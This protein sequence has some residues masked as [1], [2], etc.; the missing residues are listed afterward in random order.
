M[1]VML[2]SPLAVMLEEGVGM[3]LWWAFFMVAGLVFYTQPAFA[4]EAGQE[5]AYPSTESVFNAAKKR[6][7]TGGKEDWLYFARSLDGNLKGSHVDPQQATQWYR[8]A[9]EAGNAEAAYAMGKRYEEGY[10]VEQDDRKAFEWY[11]RA[12]EARF[13]PAMGKVGKFH[14]YGKAIPQS[15]VEA[16]FWFERMRHPWFRQPE[17]AAQAAAKLTPREMA[18]VQERLAAVRA[19]ERNRDKIAK[20]KGKLSHPFARWWGWPIF[21]WSIL[22]GASFRQESFKHATGAPFWVWLGISFSAGCLAGMLL[23]AASVAT[24][25]FIFLGVLLFVLGMFAVSALL[26]G[27]CVLL[28][29][30]FFC[31]DKIQTRLR[32]AGI[33]VGSFA[34]GGMFGALVLIKPVVRLFS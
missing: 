20:F 22:L 34:G 25:A 8:R 1:P 7:E 30:S 33:A 21:L 28:F 9:A 27:S 29:S 26:W 4:A 2:F 18:A 32:L 13:G 23:M 15:Y 11:M 3:H 10:T 5:S 16:S 31:K 6:A 14:F 24:F 12:A 17:E 19:E